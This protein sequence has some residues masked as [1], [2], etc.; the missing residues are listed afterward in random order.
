MLLAIGYEEMKV[1]NY[2]ESIRVIDNSLS[3]LV[4]EIQSKNIKTFKLLQTK[5]KLSQTNMLVAQ[6]RRELTS[7]RFTEPNKM[8]DKGFENNL[9]LNKALQLRI[10]KI[11]ESIIQGQKI[12]EKSTNKVENKPRVVSPWEDSNG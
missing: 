11:N 1:V 8:L 5:S 4:Y 7:M 12:N 10:I 3:I 2:G 6:I 9:K